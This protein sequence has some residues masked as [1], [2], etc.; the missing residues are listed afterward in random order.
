MAGMGREETRRKGVVEIPLAKGLSVVIDAKDECWVR[1]FKWNAHRVGNTVYARTSFPRKLYLH[2]LIVKAPAGGTVDHKNGNGLDNRRQNL[3]PATR[4]Q[5]GQNSRSRR[6]ST[7]VF[8]GVC[9]DKER[10]GWIAQIK[11]SNDSRRRIGRFQTEEE[12]ARAYDAEALQAFGEFA[13]LNF[14]I[15]QEASRVSS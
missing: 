5:N 14:P 7:S 11:R 10:G 1:A 6:N 8:L 12:A 4:R 9:K 15:Q 2:E 3:R 13:N